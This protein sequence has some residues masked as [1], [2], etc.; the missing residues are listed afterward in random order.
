MFV[1]LFLQF[2]FCKLAHGIWEKHAASIVQCGFSCFGEWQLSSSTEATGLLEKT[3]ACILTGIAIASVTVTEDH[4]F[5]FVNSG[6]VQRG[7]G[8]YKFELHSRQWKYGYTYTFRN[9][10]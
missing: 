1:I 8:Q 6:S 3:K 4:Q 9:K 2:S 7:S 5:S 10:E